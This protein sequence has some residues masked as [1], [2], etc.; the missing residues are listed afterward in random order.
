MQAM[1]EV[2]NVVRIRLTFRMEL[3]RLCRRGR[4]EAPRY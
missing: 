2:E 1:I 4:I 3:P